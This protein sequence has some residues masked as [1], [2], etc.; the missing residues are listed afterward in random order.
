MFLFVKIE[1]AFLFDISL[2]LLKFLTYMY[3]ALP[4]EHYL[5]GH[6]VP[7]FKRGPNLLCF[8]L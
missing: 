2:T 1:F 7:E 8:S 3:A 5:F 6:T 4:L